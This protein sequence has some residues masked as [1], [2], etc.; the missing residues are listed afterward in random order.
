MDENKVI[1]RK[2][3][4]LLL[5][6]I[7]SLGFFVDAGDLV[8]ASLVRAQSIKELGIATDK[9]AIKQIGL[10]LESWQSWGILFGGIIWGIFGDKLGRRN[11]LYGSIALYSLAT[12]LNGFLNPSWGNVL[13]FYK[14]LRFLSG[15]GLAG[16]FG[17]GA[18]LIMEAMRKETRGIGSMVLAAFGTLGCVAAAILAAYAKLPWDTLFK[19]GGV[20]GLVLLIFRIG[21]HESA[22]FRNQKKS[23]VPQGAFLSIFTNADRLKRYAI[24]I[25]IGLPTYYVVGLPIKFAANFGDALKLTGVNVPIA[26]ITFYIA[27]S[28]G[29]VICNSISQYL[30]TRKKMFIFYNI[31][32][33]LAILL[34]T[35]Y[36]PSNAW[37]YHFVYCPILGFS[38]GYWALVVTVAA[39]SFGTNIRA[40][41]TTTVPNIIRSSFIV[42]AVAFTALEGKLG[43]IHAGGI[44]GIVCSGIAIIASLQ[45]KETFGKDLNFEEK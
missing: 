44:I 20:A 11:A 27:M 10:T 41:V 9:D 7:A 29:D 12:L 18:T 5:I 40:T 34:F 31:L 35:Y 42:I 37:Q 45:L 23:V 6:I 38:V 25:L 22:I 19:I 13:L 4:L 8:I 24:C 14:V 3:P 16:E 1:L 36:P 30:K 33:L 15:L 2:T 32:N 43:T 17:V 28:F 21:V 26:M 39:E